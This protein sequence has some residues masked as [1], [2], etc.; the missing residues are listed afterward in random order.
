MHGKN[1][2]SSRTSPCMETFM[3]L[4]LSFAALILDAEIISFD[5]CEMERC[6]QTDAGVRVRL[7][8]ETSR[9][10]KD[11]EVEL[12]ESGQVSVEDIGGNM[13]DCCFSSKVAYIPS[14]KLVQKAAANSGVSGM[15][16]SL[17]GGIN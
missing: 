2:R 9:T 17:D 4:K 1:C 12:D 10:F 11:Q 13:V 8:D 6:H 7:A 3:S 14:E 15:K 16:V 5:G